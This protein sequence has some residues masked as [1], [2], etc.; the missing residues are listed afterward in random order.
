MTEDVL[1]SRQ[2]HVLTIQLNR[3]AQRNAMTRDAAATIA[4]ALDE[5]DNDSGLIVAILTGAGGSFCAGMDLKRFREGELPSLP[6]RGF[7]GVT[8]KPPAKPLIAAVEGYALGGG[9][10]LV[11]ACDLVVASSGA[12]FGLPEVKRGLVARAGGLLRLAERLPYAVAMEIALSGELISAERAFA[13]GLVNHV[14]P[15]GKALVAAQ[16]LAATIAAN[17]PLAI[18]ASKSILRDSRGWPRDEW[19][20]RQAQITDPV[21]ASNDAIEGPAAFAEKRAPQWTGT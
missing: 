5:L 6:G 11:L 9:F 4:A 10:E 13:V 7:G 1:V 21:F 3:P 8:Q 14:V 12:K 19:W 20:I 15:E 2:D 17:A 16:E 18:A